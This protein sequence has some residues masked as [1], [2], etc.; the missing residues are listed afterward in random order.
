MNS[1]VQDLFQNGEL[2]GRLVRFDDWIV[3]YINADNGIQHYP[4]IGNK[5]EKISKLHHQTLLWKIK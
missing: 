1:V 3:I 2:G 4:Y 5:K